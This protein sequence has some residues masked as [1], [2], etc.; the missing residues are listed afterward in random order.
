MGKVAT[1]SSVRRPQHRGTPLPDGWPVVRTAAGQKPTTMSRLS[2][3][4]GWLSD[5][6]TGQASGSRKANALYGTMW[7]K[8]GGSLLGLHMKDQHAG[9]TQCS[10]VSNPLAS[11]TLTV[12][13]AGCGLFARLQALQTWQAQWRPESVL[14]LK[15]YGITV[16][17]SQPHS[18]TP[19]IR[20]AGSAWAAC[21]ICP[22]LDCALCSVF[23]QPPVWICIGEC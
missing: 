5:M 6:E 10:P 14:G 19:L 1:D 3:A 22:N 15:G 21:H 23:H 8:P 12:E 11:A 4:G 2:R 9:P 7:R 18:H 17:G 20:S 13:G 16:E